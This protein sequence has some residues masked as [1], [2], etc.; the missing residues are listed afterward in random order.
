MLNKKALQVQGSLFY[1][2]HSFFRQAINLV[3][4][5]LSSTGNTWKKKKKTYNKVQS[6]LSRHLGRLHGHITPRPELRLLFGMKFHALY[7][8]VFNLQKGIIYYC[9]VDK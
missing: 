8:E 3:D 1:R 9:V 7:L 5:T 6:R 2:E 4:R